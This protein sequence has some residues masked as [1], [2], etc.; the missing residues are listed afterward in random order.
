M[1][2]TYTWEEIVEFKC[3]WLGLILTKNELNVKY[4]RIITIYLML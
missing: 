3:E 2:K 1:W 4:I